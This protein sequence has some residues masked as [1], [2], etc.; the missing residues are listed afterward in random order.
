[1]HFLLLKEEKCHG[2]TIIESFFQK[3]IYGKGIKRWFR[4][5]RVVQK[6]ASPI[7]LGVDLIN[8]IDDFGFKKVTELD[9]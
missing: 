9:G 5:G 3:I 7:W 2:L 8:E 1:M 4:K 6:S